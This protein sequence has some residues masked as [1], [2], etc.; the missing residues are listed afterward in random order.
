MA[1]KIHTTANGDVA[2]TEDSN[3]V[4]LGYSFNFPTLSSS[5]IYVQVGTGANIVAKST[6]T[7]YTIVNYAEDGSSNGTMH[8][9]FN[10]SAARGS[11]NVRIFRETNASTLRHTFQPASA[12]RSQDLNENQKQA[13]NLAE[14]ARELVN[15]LA[16]G[17]NQSA[18][19][20][21]GVNIATGSVNSDALINGTI[22]THDIGNGQITGDK[23]QSSTSTDSQRAVNTDHIRDG[24]VN[25]AK[26]SNIAG[27]KVTPDFGSQNIVTTGTLGSD[28]ITITGSFPS[29]N[30]TDNGQN[31]DYSIKNLDGT[32][33][34]TDNTNSTVKLQVNS[35]DGHV[36]L[37]SHVDIGAGLDVTGTCAATTFSGSGAN[38][39][40]LPSSALTGALPAIDGS[41]L[42][43]IGASVK[44]V[45][46]H[47]QINALTYA[48]PYN[49][50][51]THLTVTFDNVANSSKFFVI[52]LYQIATERGSVFGSGS[53]GQTVAR[54]SGVNTSLVLTQEKTTYNETSNYAIFEHF[55]YDRASNTNNR[56][57]RLQIKNAAQNRNS[58]IRRAALIVIEFTPA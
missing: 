14:E 30:L 55:D 36:D 22:Q 12:I 2:G 18:I 50:W 35:S 16:L 5:E 17:D 24:A 42:L 52:A 8:I 10:N 13:L 58:M 4:L 7:H 56:T 32:L 34:I 57:Y 47:S 49:S 9:L 29:L 38:L 41:S 43:G 39:T 48:D 19:Q 31:P 44:R 21:N 3:G 46:E 11:G 37:P 26:V 15:N 27:S 33:A 28:D 1:Q 23:L 45:K 54:I 20:L 40:N 53:T 51:Q 25:T 6:P